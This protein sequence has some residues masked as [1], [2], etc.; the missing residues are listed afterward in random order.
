MGA[1]LLDRRVTLLVKRPATRE[2]LTEALAH[3]TRNDMELKCVACGKSK[4]R[5][6]PCIWTTA[7]VKHDREKPS[8]NASCSPIARIWRFVSVASGPRHGRR[9]L[10]FSV[11]PT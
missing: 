3:A 10:S 6:G 1:P 11:L 4:R 7:C 2:Q 5:S 9:A 8:L